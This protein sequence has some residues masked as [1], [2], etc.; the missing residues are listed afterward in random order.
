M[1]EYEKVLQHLGSLGPMK[2]F[3]PYQVRVFIIVS[4]FETPAA[5]AMLLPVLINAV[6]DWTCDN[7][8][9]SNTTSNYTVNTC[10][11]D[12][13]VCS[14]ITFSKDFSSIRSEVST[15]YVVK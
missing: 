9:T 14:G 4:M 13:K 10:D 3:G 8:D 12:N 2:S 5:W 1:S 15:S 7:N 6:P 11:S